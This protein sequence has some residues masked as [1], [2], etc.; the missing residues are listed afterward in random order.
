VNPAKAMAEEATRQHLPAFS[1][2][3]AYYDKKPSDF[4]LK[5]TMIHAAGY[6]FTPATREKGIAMLHRCRFHT[7]PFDWHREHF[8]P[9]YRA[10]YIPSVPTL[11]LAGAG[12][13]ANPPYLFTKDARFSQ[14][15][16]T[17]HDIPDAGHF[18][19]VERPVQVKKL[20]EHFMKGLIEE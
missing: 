3:L 5:K 8:F 10:R 1:T 17:R 11:I 6:Y 20:L 12:D 16:F 14:P 2:L 19:W 7:P 15:N 9:Y 13:R 18:P 4:R